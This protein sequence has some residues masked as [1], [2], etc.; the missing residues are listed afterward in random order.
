MMTNSN[1][2]IYANGVK[3]LLSGLNGKGTN[4]FE[5][6]ASE[7]LRRIMIDRYMKFEQTE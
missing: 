6:A 1:W 4:D 5:N 2:E 7:S 3:L